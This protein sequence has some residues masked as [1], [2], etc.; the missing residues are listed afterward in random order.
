[1]SEEIL[2]TDCVSLKEGGK[3]WK[4]TAAAPTTLER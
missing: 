1:M 4:T 2:Y 3:T